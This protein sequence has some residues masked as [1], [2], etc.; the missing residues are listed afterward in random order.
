M[1]K[2]F[3]RSLTIL[4]AI[5]IA[6]FILR[7][8]FCL[9]LIVGVVAKNGIH[10]IAFTINFILSE[11]LTRGNLEAIALLSYALLLVYLK[12]YRRPWQLKPNQYTWLSTSPWTPG[13]P[14]PG[15]DFNL[16]VA[17]IF[18]LIGIEALLYYFTAWHIGI[19]SYL[20]AI[21]YFIGFLLISFNQAT[22]KE[23]YGTLALLALPLLFID[24]FSWLV[25]GTFMLCWVLSLQAQ[26]IVWKSWLGLDENPSQNGKFVSVMEIGWPWC[27]VSELPDLQC[28]KHAWLISSVFALWLYAIFHHPQVAD[29]FEILSHWRIIT[30]LIAFAHWFTFISAGK[31]ALSIRGRIRHRKFILQ[32]YDHVH[33]TPLLCILSSAAMFT[34]AS[35]VFSDIALVET[36]AIA[37]A[38]YICLRTGPS[39]KHWSY[40]G[41]FSTHPL[42][43]KS[44]FLEKV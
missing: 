32:G 12:L 20:F 41:K 9:F 35:S 33:L 19:T 15:G 13:K 26:R 39:L 28:K 27:A 24:Y 36:L 3:L 31:P 23:L 34:L 4:A 18:N 25:T 44:G 40:T 11:W 2:Q 6:C 7:L 22:W 1:K 43:L 8:A 30:F 42:V 17:D 37:S 29:E 16:G 38:I 10:T 5:L 21:F 14:L